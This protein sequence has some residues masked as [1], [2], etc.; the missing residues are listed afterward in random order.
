VSSDELTI[1]RTVPEDR[2]EILELLRASLG[3][4][5]DPRFDLL[6]AW[7]HEENAFGESPA[8][9]ATDRDRIA[10]LRVLMRWEFVDG[11]RTVRAVRA[12]DTATHPDYQGRGIFTRLALYAIDELRDDV[13]FVFNT[14]NDQ[15]RPGYLKMGWQVVGRLPTFVR[16]T[17][18]VGL[19]RIAT[20]RVPAERWSAPSDA[21]DPAVDLLADRDALARLIDSLPEPDAVRTRLSPEFLRWRYGTPL[22][23]Y[24]AVA[25]PGGVAEGIAVFRI[26]RRGSAREAALG[27]VIAAGGDPGT[28]AALTRAV[29][30]AADADYVIALGH[31]LVAPGGLVRLPGQGPLLTWRA[32]SALRPPDAWALTLGDIEL[33]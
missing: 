25:A 7:K 1:R 18:P 19:V 24:R 16:P 20:A 26:R 8:W 11:G 27:D 2:A 13:S 29:T 9:V 5:A 10:G 3:R 21:A 23:G 32:V 6:Y 12:V 22:L 15:S 4:D 33:F 17:G 14:P 31:G 28:A 30:R